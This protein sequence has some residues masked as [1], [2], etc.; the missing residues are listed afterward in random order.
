MGERAP[1]KENPSHSSADPLI[2]ADGATLHTLYVDATAAG[3]YTYASHGEMLEGGEGDESQG[4]PDQG[5][6]PARQ[7]YYRGFKPRFSPRAPP[8]PRPAQEGEEDKEN[9]GGEGGQN[10]QPRQRRYR[11][12]FNY[13]RRRPQ[14][15]DKPG[16]EN[17]EAKTG[18]DPPAEKTSAPEAQQGGAE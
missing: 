17:K 5:K 18:G 9:Q 8:R 1:L 12:N 7:S 6:Q 13:R 15:G 2:P 14:A 3:P 11:R 10:Q 4:G 16:P